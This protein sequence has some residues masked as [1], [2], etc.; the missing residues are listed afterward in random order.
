MDAGGGTPVLDWTDGADPGVAAQLRAMAALPVVGPHVAAMPDA[1]VGIGATVGSVIP[2]RGAVIPAA[3]GTD[4]GCGMLAVRTSASAS[5][6]PDGLGALRAGIEARIPVGKRSHGAVPKVGRGGRALDARYERILARTPALAYRGKGRKPAIHWSLQLGTLGG[7]N[8]FVEICLDDEQRV[9]IM[10]HSG[11]RNA[12]T[13]IASH[14]IERAKEQRRER[15]GRTPD[16]AALSWLDEGTRAFEGYVEAVG[17]AQ[18][19]AAANR[20]AMLERSAEALREAVG[21]FTYEGAVVSCHHNYVAREEHFGETLWITRKGAIEASRGALGIVPGSMGAKSFIVRGRGEASSFRSC[22]HGAGRR[23][24]RSR[25]KARYGARDVAAQ[26]VGVECR[27]DA[28][29]ADEAPGAYKDVEDVMARQA[30][31]VEVVH[32]LKQVVCVKG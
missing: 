29:V 7:G 14:W 13:R 24:S 26:T 6:L 16:D 5:H 2:T 3:L 17:W 4:I 1:H 20:R 28:G 23:L 21:D 15:D 32:V 11:S 27:K 25:A 22:A 18:D 10:L 19:F 12:G 31:L 9:W 30:D 8:H